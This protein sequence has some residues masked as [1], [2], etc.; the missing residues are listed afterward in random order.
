MVSPS[1]PA[2]LSETSTPKTITSVP[3]GSPT[4]M[5]SAAEAEGLALEK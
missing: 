2:Q 1:N 3:G 4:S 5:H